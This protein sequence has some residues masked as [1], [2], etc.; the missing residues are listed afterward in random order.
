MTTTKLKKLKKIALERINGEI[1]IGLSLRQEF[2]TKEGMKSTDIP[3]HLRREYDSLP[4]KIHLATKKSS[5]H[6]KALLVA[7]NYVGENYYEVDDFWSKATYGGK[8]PD[9]QKFLDLTEKDIKKSCYRRAFSRLIQWALDS[10]KNFSDPG[11]FGLFPVE[12][13]FVEAGTRNVVETLAKNNNKHDLRE[14]DSLKIKLI[15]DTYKEL[16]KTPGSGRLKIQS[17]CKK[18]TGAPYLFEIRPDY[19]FYY[20]VDQNDL[21]GIYEIET[22]IWEW[23]WKERVLMPDK[24]SKIEEFSAPYHQLSIREP[25][26]TDDIASARQFN[27]ICSKILIDMSSS[28]DDC[29]EVAH[30]YGNVMPPSAI[31]KKTEEAINLRNAVA[32][33]ALLM[34]LVKYEPSWPDIPRF[35][36][37]INR[38]TAIETLQNA[39]GIDVESFETMSGVEFENFI[40]SMFEKIGFKVEVTPKTA[41]Y[42]ADII[43]ITPNASRIAIQCKRFKSKVNLKAVQEVVASLSHYQCDYGV[44]ITNND[45]LNSAKKLAANNEVELWDK[46][47]LIKFLAGNIS[48]SELRNL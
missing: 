8:R 12:K 21:K 22:K 31:A 5:I 24:K 40:A 38:L 29:I 13:V 2:L 11:E 36:K 7:L 32:S 35:E 19:E 44:V 41:D 17:L 18:L 37:E 16:E 23:T 3:P 45:F 26:E 48:F 28:L 27:E 20:H 6:E 15:V 25:F 34:C 14:D 33:Q 42:G 10:E 1:S 9:F 47:C 30:E 4:I 43:V 39:E 46:D